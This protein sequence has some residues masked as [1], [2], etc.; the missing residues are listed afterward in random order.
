MCDFSLSKHS[1]II[2]VSVRA[3]NNPQ[4]LHL[5]KAPQASYLPEIYKVPFL[6]AHV[7]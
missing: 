1:G 3:A 6:L 5:Q 2:V 4:N 7:N